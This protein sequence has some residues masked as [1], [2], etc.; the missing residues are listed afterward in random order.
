MPHVLTDPDVPDLLTSADLGPLA[1]GIAHRHGLDTLAAAYAAA[2][3]ESATHGAWEQ[4]GNASYREWL[5][6]I[7]EPVLT[8]TFALAA[9]AAHDNA[10][11][12]HHID[13]AIAVLGAVADQ[14]GH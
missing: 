13:T 14:L 12:L 8:A 7:P 2:I 5:S 3:A 10:A 9:T 11:A 1:S 6:G 4:L